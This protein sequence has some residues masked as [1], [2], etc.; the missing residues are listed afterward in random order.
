MIFTRRPVES[1]PEA[2]PMIF[3]R[4]PLNGGRAA[5]PVESWPE[6]MK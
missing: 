4:S 6:A 2:P 5:S 3:L 1:W